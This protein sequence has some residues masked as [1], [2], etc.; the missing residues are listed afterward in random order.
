MSNFITRWFR[1]NENGPTREDGEQL[2]SPATYSQQAAA[3]VS[4]DTAMTVSAFWACTRLLSETV[5]AL[6]IKAFD[7][8]GTTKTQTTDYDLWRVLNF[9]PNRYQT[10]VE[11]METITLNLVTDGNAYSAIQRSPNG[12]IISLIPLMS[13]Q[14]KV[15]LLDDGAIT[16]Q[17]TNASGDIVVYAEESIW[18]LKLFGNGIVGLSPLAYARQSLGIAIAI[19]NRVSTL[20]KNGGRTSGILTIDKVLTPEQRKEVKKNFKGL[21]EGNNDQLFVLEAGF[22]YTQTALSPADMQM[23]ESR[24][25]QVEDICR[26]MGV[27]SVLVND[28]SGTTA[29]GSGI[30]QIMDGFYKINL[31]PYLERYEASIKKNLMPVKDWETME[32]EFDFDALLRA[33]ITA[34]TASAKDRVNSGL[35]TP[36]E[37]RQQEGLPPKPGGDDIYLNGTMVPAGTTGVD[38]GQNN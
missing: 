32:I 35:M 30:Q 11:Y 10:R 22:D 12:K 7:V 17:Y 9:R 34:R 16:Y 20:A 5:A 13:A 36:N 21:T 19:D 8:D 33:D 37:G 28:T 24:R 2:S 4:F 29:W 38:D 3:N 23:L 6:P 27:P 18:H 15:A 1:R 14:M 25:F 26:F 31:R